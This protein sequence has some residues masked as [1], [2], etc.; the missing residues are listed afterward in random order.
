MASRF[1]ARSAGVRTGEDSDGVTAGGDGVT[2]GGDSDRVG[3]GGDCHGIDKR[4]LGNVPLQAPFSSGG[5]F[6]SHQLGTIP[7]DFAEPSIGLLY[8]EIGQ[9]SDLHRGHRVGI[10]ARAD[11][12]APFRHP[13]GREELQKTPPRP[14]VSASHT[15][16]RSPPPPS[17]APF[18]PRTQQPP[19][20]R[21]P[22]CTPYAAHLASSPGIPEA[23]VNATTPTEPA[24]DSEV[25]GL[26][27]QRRLSS[28]AGRAQAK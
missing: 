23:R 5:L 6:P 25:A 15:G 13:N 7:M 2:T 26:L 17:P 14:S 9:K 3:T 8:R 24:G 11:R 16:P 22:A 18:T 19:N 12:P 21:R 28:Q 4:H 27:L 10:P 20:P 1:S